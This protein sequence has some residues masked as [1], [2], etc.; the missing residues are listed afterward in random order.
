MDEQVKLNQGTLKDIFD[1]FEM[2]ETQRNRLLSAHQKNPNRNVDF[3]VIREMLRDAKNL[4]SFDGINSKKKF[5]D[6]LENSIKELIV[7]PT[8]EATTT[9][10]KQGES[11]NSL[12]NL[13]IINSP[14]FIVNNAPETKSAS[15]R[16]GIVSVVGL[17]ALALVILSILVFG[18]VA[19]FLR[20]NTTVSMIE[21][22]KTDAAF[23]CALPATTVTIFS[24][25]T[26]ATLRSDTETSTHPVIK[27]A[28]NECKKKNWTI[29]DKNSGKHYILQ[30][31]CN[32][33]AEFFWTPNTSEACH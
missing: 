25:E 31:N 8:S 9:Q 10:T 32:G 18:I 29:Q 3:L 33:S 11:E 24:D 15:E 16:L 5:T 26:S 23:V 21:N 17:I 30:A 1:E 4:G 20:N 19:L 7:G 27:T 22:P 13:K 28:T 6:E 2:E 12:H 14:K